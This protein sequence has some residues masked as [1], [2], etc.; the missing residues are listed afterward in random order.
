MEAHDFLRTLAIVLVTAGITATVFQR[1]RLPVVFGYMAAGLAIG[2][3][4]PF[5][6]I[7]ADEQTVHMLS[8]LGVILLMFALGLEFSL[9]RVIR[10]FP[11]A[12][13]IALAQSAFLGLAGYLTGQA[14][15]WTTLES[16]FAGA[17]IAISSTTIIVK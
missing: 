13:V 7:V 2:P 17:I 12:G 11:T 10:I 8:E 4:F 5:L 16:I 6:P 9:R 15:G 3:H 14:F 1:L